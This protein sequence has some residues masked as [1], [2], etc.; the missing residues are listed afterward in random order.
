MD[1]RN[2]AIAKSNYRQLRLTVTHEISGRFS[3]SLYAKPLQA[4]WHEHQCLLRSACDGTRLPLLTTEDAIL[5]AI[6]CLE[7][8]TFAPITR[9][10]Q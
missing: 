5:A 1:S 8:Q 7:E 10:R 6:V 4:A 3:Y 9:L 2:S